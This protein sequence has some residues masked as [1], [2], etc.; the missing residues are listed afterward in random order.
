MKRRSIVKFI[1]LGVLVLGGSAGVADVLMLDTFNNEG[2]TVNEINA[3]LANRQSGSQATASWED[4]TGTAGGTSWLTK[5]DADA[6]RL[7]KNVS[8]ST[9][10]RLNRDFNAAS[11]DVRIAV[12]IKN[13]NPTVG[14]SMVNFGLNWADGLAAAAGYSF[15]LDS[16]YAVKKL[17]FFDNGTEKGSMDVT[18]IISATAAYESLVVDFTN[19][20]TISATLNG[21]AYEFSS[22]EESYT[23]TIETKNYV[24]LGWYNGSASNTSAS[25]DNLSVTSIPEPAT[26][27]MVLCASL[28]LLFIRRSIMR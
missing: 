11:S 8:G 14:F 13:M 17:K 28:G 21:T 1:M 9:F 26:L 22:G 7:F 4:N 12:D 23:G 16:R 19:A 5:I 18:S 3:D 24:M 27:G 25:F 10:A 2:V 6:L 20:D 15:R